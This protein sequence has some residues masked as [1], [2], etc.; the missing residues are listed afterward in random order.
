MRKLLVWVIMFVVGLL[1][2]FVSQYG[3]A[4]RLGA[5]L[6]ACAA[7]ADLAKVRKSGALTYIAAT[8]LNYGVA[9][10]Y[11]Q[12]FFTD[13]QSLQ[14]STTDASLKDAL[15]QTLSARDKI[16]ADLAKGSAESLGELQPLV[17]KLEQVGD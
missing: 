10:G 7:H 1:I 14:A 8:Q 3:K 12:T 15:S 11:A 16:T 6:K 9:S 5:E 4:S 2:G 13:V 17:L